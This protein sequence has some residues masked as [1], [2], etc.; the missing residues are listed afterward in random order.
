[1]I[2]ICV[3]GNIGSGKSFV[4]KQFNSPVFNADIEVNKIYKTDKKCFIK[5]RSELP[6]YVK[7]FPIKKQDLIKA[8]SDNAKNLRKI[9]LIVHPLVRKRLNMFLIRNKKKKIVVLDIPLLIEN[10]INKKR[11]VLLYVNSS[12]SN[13][14]NRLKK[15]KNYEKKIAKILLKNQSL[16]LK[17]RKL[18]NYIIENNSSPNIM[19]KKIRELKKKIINERDS[20]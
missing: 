9:S 3:L 15:R 6:N 12:N 19:K 5:L 7:T 10:K 2:R 17:K 13:I 14:T 16:L 11:D 18:A 1:M 20:S 8:I 4:A